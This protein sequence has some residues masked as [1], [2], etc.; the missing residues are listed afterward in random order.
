MA[1]PSNWV[2]HEIGD[3][4]IF[5]HRVTAY[6]ASTFPESLHFHDYYELVI[7]ISGTIRYI[8]ENKTLLP[9]PGDI[10]LTP[11]STLHTSTLIANS[12]YDRYVFYLYPTAFDSFHGD[13]LMKFLQSGSQPYICLEQNKQQRMFSLLERIDEAF[14]EGNTGSS[15]L[16]LSYVVQLFYLLNRYGSDSSKQ[17]PH[18]PGNVMKIKGYIDEN[19]SRIQSVSQ[20]AEQFFYSREYASR[21]FKRYLNTS[22]NDYLQKRR[23]TWCRSQLETAAPI[24]DIC[25]QAG[26]RSMSSFI[27]AFS[28]L[29]GMT[30]SRYRQLLRED[31]RKK[32]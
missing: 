8:C 27:H 29:T 31:W 32:G 17:D 9:E 30:P 15:A 22:I 3:Q 14:Q 23:I 28:I 7:Y 1:T 11:P 26:F 4:M 24:K 10:I 6:N 2:N 12:Q 5:S 16:A 18:F 19:F 13:A 20:I 21:L 25:Y